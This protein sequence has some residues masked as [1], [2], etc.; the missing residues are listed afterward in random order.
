MSDQDRHLNIP[1]HDVTRQTPYVPIA[2]SFELSP[3]VYKKIEGIAAVQ[4]AQ[5]QGKKL[6]PS[7]A[8]VPR[9]EV[10]KTAAS[11]D[12]KDQAVPLMH[13]LSGRI[14]RLP[15]TAREEEAAQLYK[16]V[17]PRLDHYR[18]ML[19]QQD[20]LKDCALF[21]SLDEIYADHVLPEIERIQSPQ[22][23]Y[24]LARD[25]SGI[26]R[27]EVESV[28]DELRGNAWRLALHTHEVRT[29]P[30]G[31]RITDELY[32]SVAEGLFDPFILVDV[33]QDSNAPAPVKKFNDV[34][35]L[36]GGDSWLDE[37][38]DRLELLPDAV[39]I[40]VREL[41]DKLAK[42]I[43]TTNNVAHTNTADVLAGAADDEQFETALD[44]ASAKYNAF[45]VKN[46]Q[47]PHLI[48][49]DP[50][51]RAAHKRARPVADDEPQA[52]Y[53]NEILVEKEMFSVGEFVYD[54]TKS[55]VSERTVNDLVQSISK[56]NHALEKAI[57]G[58]FDYI[59]QKFGDK[60][61]HATGIKKS[62]ALSRGDDT[63]WEF[64]P[65]EAKGLAANTRDARAHRVYFVVDSDTNSVH[66]VDVIGRARLK[67]VERTKRK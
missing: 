47:L 17:F 22:D 3:E 50:Q 33:L 30:E 32:S 34:M 25:Y 13:V 7:M 45:L 5:E 14:L 23:L 2:H 55:E 39:A 51:R 24:R 59:G 41:R 9:R 28:E 12:A 57:L 18:R 65:S 67:T 19:M 1:E 60:S 58:C 15:A 20:A 31:E 62:Y 40:G 61:N 8:R 29:K 48:Y 21:D 6:H 63:V 16:R 11:R 43:K 27:E 52:S 42:G 49:R 53:T 37:L 36:V 4:S 10:V 46:Q 44:A 66:I 26:D 35:R 38:H 54:V 64:K 56:H